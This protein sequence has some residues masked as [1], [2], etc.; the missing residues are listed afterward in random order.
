MARKRA[1]S[2]AAWLGILAL[3]LYVLIPIHLVFDLAD[4]QEAG[5]AE[6]IERSDHG[7]SVLAAL[8][9]NQRGGGTAGEQS[10]HHARCGVCNS[11]CALAGYAPASGV[12]LPIPGLIHAIVTPATLDGV[13]SRASPAAY[14]SRA[15][16]RA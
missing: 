14:C 5:S 12:A 11:L 4:A 8:V 6:H 16:P 3:G 9:G 10:D 13:P 2:I 7:H 15:P 1:S